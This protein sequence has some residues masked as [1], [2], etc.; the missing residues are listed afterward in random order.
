VDDQ[1]L[2][3]RLILDF[4]PK[5]PPVEGQDRHLA[6][7]ARA[8]GKTYAEVSEQ[9]HDPEIGRARLMSKQVYFGAYEGISVEQFRKAL[10]RRP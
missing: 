2:V 9:K 7:V 10:V 4:D 1:E 8:L 5:R 3:A 6:N